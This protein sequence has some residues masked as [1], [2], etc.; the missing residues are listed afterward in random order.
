MVEI[1]IGYVLSVAVIISLTSLMVLFVSAYKENLIE[2]YENSAMKAVTSSVAHT[3]TAV[4]VDGQK[5][6]FI[7]TIN[8]KAILAKSI[9]VL[10]EKIS[11]KPYEIKI[12]NS[13]KLVCAYIGKKEVCSPII[14]LPL[15]FNVT[16]EI[17]SKTINISYWRENNNTIF[18][19][20]I[21]D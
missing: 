7:P 18:D 5:S 1:S 20:I 12:S 19:Y 21:I 2:R 8:G 3:L 16:G 17:I 10:P 14:G 4:Y 6:E 11:K 9:V 15:D 13:E